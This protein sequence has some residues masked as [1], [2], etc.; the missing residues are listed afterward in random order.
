MWRRGGAAPPGPPPAR[1]ER[2]RESKPRGRT[3]G[4]ADAKDNWRR[5]GGGG[6]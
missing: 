5:G 3:D 6:N 2:R 4:E 1:S